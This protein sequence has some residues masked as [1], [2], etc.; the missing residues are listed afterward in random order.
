MNKANP[1]PS[2]RQL[3]KR[4]G[5]NVRFERERKGI[6]R[7]GLAEML[8]LTVSHLGLIERGERGATAQT[9]EKLSRVLKLPIDSFFGVDE[10]RD[11]TVG[12]AEKRISPIVSEFDED[13][14]EFV[15][16]LLKDFATLKRAKKRCQDD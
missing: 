11:E 15:I 1:K 3:D 7:E 2:K 13:E 6:S 16:K 5:A 9:L 14:M 10:N 4:I 8:D 12:S